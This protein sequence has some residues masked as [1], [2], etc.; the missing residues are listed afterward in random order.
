MHIRMQV[1]GRQRQKT[2]AKLAAAILAPHCMWPPFS[3]ATVHGPQGTLLACLGIRMQNGNRGACVCACL[4]AALSPFSPPSPPS[5]SSLTKR[6]TEEE[7]TTTHAGTRTLV[8]NP[9]P[10]VC[11]GG[12]LPH[13]LSR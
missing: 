9:V 2:P 7:G 8:S 3:R 12:L 4:G 5:P 1:R 6:P 10:V 13:T 11:I